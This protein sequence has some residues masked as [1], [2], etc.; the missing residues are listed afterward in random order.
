MQD[1]SGQPAWGL[2]KMGS[3]LSEFLSEETRALL[4]EARRCSLSIGVHAGKM[5]LWPDDTSPDVDVL[6]DRLLGK[7]AEIVAAAY[8]AVEARRVVVDLK[9]LTHATNVVSLEA[10]RQAKENR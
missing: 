8:R 1:I 6:M 10:R 3:C 7:E 9:D 4:I 5:E 2:K